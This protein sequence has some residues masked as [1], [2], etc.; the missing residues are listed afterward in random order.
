[1]ISCSSTYTEYK[2]SQIEEDNWKELY[3]FKQDIK[4]HLIQFFPQP[5]TKSSQGREMHIQ[6]T[7]KYVNLLLDIDNLL[8]VPQK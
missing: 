7:K 4:A 6:Q 2:Y 3:G 5:Q 8:H 1:M